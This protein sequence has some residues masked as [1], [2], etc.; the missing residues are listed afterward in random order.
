MFWSTAYAQAA[1]GAGSRPGMLEMLFPFILIMFVFYFFQSRPQQKRMKQHQEF[2]GAMKRGDEVITSGGII[3][4]IAGL[5]D[6]FVTLEVAD[7]VRI[8]IL[9]SQISGAARDGSP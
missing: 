6:K 1:G 2:L 8:R 4:Q 5:T 3:G 9:K 7:N